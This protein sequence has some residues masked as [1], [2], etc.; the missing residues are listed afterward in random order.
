MLDPA[1]AAQGEAALR[2]SVRLSLARPGNAVQRAIY[3]ACGW[4]QFGLPLVAVLWVGWFV[5][6][7]FYGG[8]SGAGTFVAEGFAVNA[9]LLV[10]LSAG[11]P[12]LLGRLAKPSPRKAAMLGVRRGLE[13]IVDYIDGRA[14]E[15]ITTAANELDALSATRD[16]LGGALVGKA[17]A[18]TARLRRQGQTPSHTR[19][20]GGET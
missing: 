5:L 6:R 12:W 1:L 15:Q 16:E 17:S 3:S 8:A 9:V 7:G 10:G 4:L 20:Q 2:E 14:L 13:D 11:L 19:K 18:L